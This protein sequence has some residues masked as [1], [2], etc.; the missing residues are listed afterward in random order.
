MKRFL[1][2]TFLIFTLSI[3]ACSK[4]SSPA[5][6]NSSAYADNASVI[7]ENSDVS[8]EQSDITQT[9]SFVETTVESS[10]EDTTSHPEDSSFESSLEIS[11]NDSSN[12]NDASQPPVVTPP[13]DITTPTKVFESNGVLIAGTRG[14]EKYGGSTASGTAYCNILSNFQKDLGSDIQVY[15]IV[16][17]HASC[18]YAPESYSSLIDN[19]SRNFDNLKN[20]TSGGVKY[21]DVYQTLWDHVDENIYPRTEHHWNA[22]AAYYAAEQFAQMA[23]VSFPSLDSYKKI[24]KSGFVGSLYSFSKSSVLKNNPEDFEIYMPQNSYTAYFCNKGNYNFDKYN[25]Q[26]NSVVFDVKSYPG[27]FLGGDSVSVKIVTG[28]N[29]GRKLVIFKDSYGNAFVPF[30][31][32]SFDE[33]YVLDIRYYNQNGVKFC[34]NVG[35]TDVAFVVSGF[36]AT[37]SVYK[38]IEKIRTAK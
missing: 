19:G 23:N 2:S 5:E 8:F 26:R 1:I 32:S 34:Q 17:P 28:N 9:E 31:V 10:F 13:S 14:M 37:G 18:Y 24:V 33:I 35:A 6:D 38:Y 25:Y 22:L 7:S 30:T 29:T 27:A 36:T 21:V 20:Q 16:A 12:A 3:T 4:I 15:S 11:N